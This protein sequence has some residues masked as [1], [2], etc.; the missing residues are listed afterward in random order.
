MQSMQKHRRAPQNHGF[1]AQCIRQL[2][3][4]AYPAYPCTHRLLGAVRREGLWRRFP[5]GDSPPDCNHDDCSVGGAL[6]VVHI[7]HVLVLLLF[8][9]QYCPQFELADAAAPARLALA[10]TQNVWD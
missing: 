1:T 6:A 3:H 8:V 9:E 7:H 5:G 2:A 4:P 10:P